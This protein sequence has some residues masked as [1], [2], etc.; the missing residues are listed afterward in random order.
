MCSV[1]VLKSLVLVLVLVLVPRIA[2]ILDGFKPLFFLLLSEGKAGGK[3]GPNARGK[4][5]EHC[6]R[7]GQ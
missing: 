3:A 4:G 1:G 5:P 7:L 6:F 2:K